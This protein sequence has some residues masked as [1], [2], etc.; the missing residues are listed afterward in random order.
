M[1]ALWQSG[2]QATPL[3]DLKSAL[4]A[5]NK[6]GQIVMSEVSELTEL[7]AFASPITIKDVKIGTLDENPNFLLVSGKV[8][9]FGLTDVDIMLTACAGVSP[10]G[11]EKFDYSLSFAVKLPDEWGITDYFSDAPDD[12]KG[13]FAPLTIKGGA[14]ASHLIDTA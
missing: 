7:Q 5:A 3:E 14:M 8:D 1:F 10:V 11:E 4:D 13:I 6:D 2:V 12:I 9:L